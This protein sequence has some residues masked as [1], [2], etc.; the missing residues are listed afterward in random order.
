MKQYLKIA[1]VLFCICAVAAGL[2]AGINAITA[3][4]IAANALKE[5]SAALMDISGGFDLG[6]KRDGNGAG[7]NYSIT[8][9]EGKEIKG[10]VLEITSNGYGGPITLVASY[11]T[12]GAVGAAKGAGIG[13]G[14]YADNNEAFA[15]LRKIEEIAP[16]ADR[17]P[18]I[19]AY[20][21]WKQY[22]ANEM[23]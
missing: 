23:A 5:T 15:S 10:Y 4:Q 12:D 2:L 16:A 7:I 11:D 8:L 6:E 1:S 9:V 18:Y 14:I 19:E 17:T 13:A 22:L 3:P 21:R 20:A